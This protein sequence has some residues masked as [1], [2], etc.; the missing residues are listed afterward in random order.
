MTPR[1]AVARKRAKSDAPLHAID[2]FAGAGGLS[3]GFKSAGFVV[4]AAFERDDW[5]SDTY[6]FNN[7]TTRLYRT[8][9]S[10]VSNF[11]FSQYFG[12]DA[13][14]GGPPCAARIIS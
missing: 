5:A 13:L 9:I 7:R 2:L 6:E 8:D 14:I 12:V 10:E 3:L 1:S 4:D 11:E